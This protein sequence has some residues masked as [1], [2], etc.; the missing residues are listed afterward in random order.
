MN[1][2]L[3][4]ITAQYRKFNDNQALTENQLNELIDYF[5]DQDRLS[6]T[7]LS[8]TGIVCGFNIKQA[9]KTKEIT[10]SQGAGVTTDGD[11]ITLQKK[12]AGNKEYA[13][14][15]ENK[16]YT[17]FRIYKD[18][19]FYPNFK[20]GST[21]GG[22]MDAVEQISLYE[23]RN[24]KDILESEKASFTP[25]IKS[26][27]AARQMTVLLYLEGVVN[28]ECG[29]EGI[30]CNNQGKEQVGTLRVL[31]TNPRYVDLIIN[32]T[33]QDDIYNKHNSIENLY[34]NLPNIQVS[35]AILKPE[36][37]TEVTLINQFNTA[38]EN[39]G[40]IGKLSN[41][42]MLIAKEFNIE[43][44]LAGET[45]L[46]KLT[47]MLRVTGT[48]D[49]QY[50]YD[51]LKDL[52]ATYNEIKALLLSLKAECCPDIKSFSKHLMLGTLDPIKGVGIDTHRHSFY[53]S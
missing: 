22:V 1:T 53:K 48:K 5:E 31:L 4:N 9:I 26:E 44:S 23:L 41:G 24:E 37:T 3:A 2:K 14:E 8:G 21:R 47:N 6:R 28:A 38:I 45:L 17:H 7:R 25:I 49:F 52:V 15:L 51:L 34:K 42:F 50:R 35:R 19:S 27:F 33:T 36:I 43:L 20:N 39:D 10:I 11:L 40:I 30:D 18:P 12:I 46:N 32:G 16:T 13:I 29:C